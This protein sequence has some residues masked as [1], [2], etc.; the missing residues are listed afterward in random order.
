MKS[1]MKVHISL[2]TMVLGALRTGVS[3]ELCAF[4]VFAILV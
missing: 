3:H 4:R 1:G 2:K